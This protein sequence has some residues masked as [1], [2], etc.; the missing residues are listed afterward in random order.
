MSLTPFDP[1]SAALVASWAAGDA[2]V[3]RA[4]IAIEADAVPAEVVAGWADEDDVE[5]FVF[6]EAADGTPVA[7]GELWL[8]HDEG[9][10]ELAHLLVAPER[11]GQGVGRAFVRALAE[12]AR[13]THPELSLVLL[14][15]QPENVRAIRAYAAAGFVDVPADE[16]VTW[17]EGQ[18]A[19]YHWM[20][21]PSS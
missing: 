15:V 7:Y 14:R 5:A 8:D 20:V 2:S 9:D 16:Q 11:R 13:R 18:R 19:T 12:H 6:S 3:V 21:L 1:A 10:V 4:W 17:N